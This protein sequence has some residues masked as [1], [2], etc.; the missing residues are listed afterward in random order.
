MHPT[1]LMACRLGDARP[2]A[3]GSPSASRRRASTIHSPGGSHL[4]RG[5]L[6]A[7]C[8]RVTR[9]QRRR[10]VVVLE[11]A[12]VI[13]DRARHLLHARNKKGDTPL[14]Y[15]AR[16]GGIRMVSLLIDLAAT[17]ERCQLLRATNASWETALHEVVRAGS[18]DI[19]VQLMAEDC[20]L[21][22]FPRDGGISPLYLAVLLDEIDIARSLY[23]MS[24]GNL[25]YSGPGRCN[26]DVF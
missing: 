13:H 5:E 20:E 12:K 10:V 16:A 26:E 3:E 11:S 21:A 4:R 18:K 8:G 15:G 24:H 1:L 9:R 19:V 7:P 17:G 2:A 23:V 6:C 14:H 25:S 22:G